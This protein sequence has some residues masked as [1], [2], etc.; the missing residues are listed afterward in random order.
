MSAVSFI[1]RKRLANIPAHLR[2]RHEY[3]F[4][5][6]DQCVAA[7]AEYENAKAHFT[8][9]HFASKE[10]GE[11]FARMAKD[12]PL[13]ALQQTANTGEARRAVINQ[14]VMA[15]ASDCLHHIYEGLRC[16]EK[17]KFSVA[18]HLLRKPFKQNMLHLA[19]ML[20]DE[21][22]FYRDFMAGSPRLLSESRIGNNRA[23]IL[24]GAIEEIFVGKIYTPELL[25]GLLYDHANSD[26]FA[27]L[28][29]HAAHLVTMKRAEIQTD[30]RNFNFIFNNPANDDLYKLAYQNLPYLMLFLSH[31]IIGLFNRMKSMD[32]GAR[33]AFEARS[34]IGLILLDELDAT[35]M[36][37]TFNKA[38]AGKGISCSMCKSE[39]SVTRHS[40]MKM[41]LVDEY[42]CSSCRAINAFPF[43]YM[44]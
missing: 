11:T 24:R 36:L 8:T 13:E 7:L 35:D 43:S 20:G 25:D 27:G 37:N 41:V 22:A 23:E 38:F 18:F 30:P 26:G 9:V 6:H 16:L 12:D 40:A 28:F 1:P 10:V 15:M 29:E 33:Q 5:L 42:R 14:I 4:F 2:V 21:E 17:R 19:W 31:V 32:P 34:S 39:L 44:F 3:C